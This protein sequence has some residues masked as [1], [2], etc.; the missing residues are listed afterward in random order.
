MTRD[1]LPKARPP[2]AKRTHRDDLEVDESHRAWRYFVVDRHGEC[3]ARAARRPASG[4]RGRA[5]ADCRT[6]AGSDVPSGGRGARAAAA[7]RAVAPAHRCLERVAHLAADARNSRMLPEPSPPPSTP[8]QRSAVWAS[9]ELRR[10]PYQAS[11]WRVLLRAHAN[12]FESPIRRGAA[13]RRRRR[14]AVATPP[15]D[16]VPPRAPPTRRRGRGR[17][18]GPVASHWSPAPYALRPADPDASRPAHRGAG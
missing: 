15:S 8:R 1:P 14:V 4:P 12:A 13:R 7:G 2:T 3:Q 11:H 6:G 5:V 9:R 17:C 16:G 18:W 10:L